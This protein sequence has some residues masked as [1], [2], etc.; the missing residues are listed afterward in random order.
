M[1]RFQIIL[2]AYFLKV[3]I[4]LENFILLAIQMGHKKNEIISRYLV[5]ITCLKQRHPLILNPNDDIPM[6]QFVCINPTFHGTGGKNKILTK[7]GRV[8]NK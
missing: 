8:K 1:Y 3:S 7:F 6:E 2:L 4:L 5:Q